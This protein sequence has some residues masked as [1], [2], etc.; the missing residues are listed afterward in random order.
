MRSLFSGR[1]RLTLFF[2][3]MLT[4][5]GVGSVL[6]DEADGFPFDRFSITVG[7]FYET[8]DADLRVD[9]SGG[10]QGTPINL[11]RD[12]GLDDTDQL[13]RLEATWRPFQR[14]QFT[15][16]YFDLSTKGHRT[17]EREI[18]FG[19]TVF[20]VRASVDSALEVQVAEL[21]YTFWALKR[22]RGGIGLSFGVS[23]LAID[24]SLSAQLDRPTSPGTS[25]RRDASTSADLPIPL[26]G[27]EG[28]YALGTHFLI[29]ANARYL[30]EITIDQYTG[31]AYSFG[32]SLEYRFV[33]HLGLGLSW[34]SFNIDA[35]V[36]RDRLD[37]SVNFT[38][39][40]AQLYLKAAM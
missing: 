12:L 2:A 26:F 11:N 14:S 6:A 4:M 20:P 21:Y 36:D 34:N 33:R 35:D 3:V 8:T 9:V 23:A 1:F 16:G 27:A 22:P 28:L 30:P 29:G 40:G 37:G 17:L 39:E 24:T 38:I 7:S 13:L 15:A 25:L 5:L 10:R 32:A 19:D 18:D 31:S